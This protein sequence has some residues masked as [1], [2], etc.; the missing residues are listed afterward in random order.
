MNGQTR[1]L[2]PPTQGWPQA[3]GHSGSSDIR[4]TST[5]QRSR[6]R[7]PQPSEARE[8]LKTV[9]EER[10]RRNA[11]RATRERPDSPAPARSDGTPQWFSPAPAAGWARRP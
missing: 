6:L 9:E 8:L 7:A 3:D 4:A 5:T 2:P 11:D 1:T 10:S